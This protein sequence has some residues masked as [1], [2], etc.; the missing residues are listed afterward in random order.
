MSKHWSYDK[1]QSK[2]DLYGSNPPTSCTSDLES[3]TL[4]FP[5]LNSAEPSNQAF[6][7][8]SKNF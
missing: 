6:H 7:Q 5:S 3:L 4:A 8:H 2:A 1:S